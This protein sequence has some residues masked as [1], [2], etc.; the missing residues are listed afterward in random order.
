MSTCSLKIIKLIFK[1]TDE[2]YFSSISSKKR[3]LKAKDLVEVEIS[4]HKP[5]RIRFTSGQ[6]AIDYPVLLGLSNAEVKCLYLRK[7]SVIF[8][9]AEP[10]LE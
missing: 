9:V 10:I 6:K 8:L 5:L 2:C 4:D 7:F 1:G 3:Q